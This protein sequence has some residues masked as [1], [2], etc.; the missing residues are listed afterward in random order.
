MAELQKIVLVDDEKTTIQIA[1]KALSEYIVTTFQD[2]KKA[3]QHCLTKDFDLLICDQKMPGMTGLELIKEVSSK[4]SDFLSIVISAFTDSDI[5]ISA[6]NSKLL[7]QYIVKPLEVVKLAELTRKAIGDL[8]T[9][10]HEKRVVQQRYEENLKLRSENTLL[11]L[12]AENSIDAIYGNHPSIIRLKEQIKTYANS[13]HPVLVSGEEGTGKK[14]FA[15]V[16]H[17]ISAR[18]DER[19]VH[20]DTTNYSSELLET[21]LFGSIKTGTKTERTGFIQSAHKG[22]LYI[23]DFTQLDKA[24]QS[25]LL[26]LIN[27]GTFYPIGGTEEKAVDVRM[28]F[29]TG[30]GIGKD[31]QSGKVRKDL[32]YKIGNLVV[33]CPTLR[34]RRSDIMGMIGFLAERKKQNF[35]VM[36]NNVK[37]FFIKY[38]YPGNVRELEGL[39]EKVLVH[40]KSNNSDRITSEDLQTIFRDNIEMYRAVQGEDAVIRTIQLPTGIEQFSM[41]KFVESIETELIQSALGINNLN[42]SQTARTL[43]ISR[44]GL[45]NK[46]KRYGLEGYDDSEDDGEDTDYA[47]DVEET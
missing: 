9:I 46:I 25:K 13:D 20:F 15:R 37:E 11:R 8:T 30:P 19:F 12:S 24:V 45:K 40:M 21:E 28:I 34:E 18:R 31:V 22:T 14:L 43:M 27:Y 35:P 41:K 17:D 38:L 29:S 44:Q 6:V 36:D 32:F 3:L 10:R 42:I 7:Y 2:P 39:M 23:E 16:I 26:R 47:D 1:E 33:K 5:M 4:K